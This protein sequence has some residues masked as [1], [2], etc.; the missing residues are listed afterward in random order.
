MSTVNVNQIEGHGGRIILEENSELVINQQLVLPVKGNK[1]QALMDGGFGSFSYDSDGDET[2]LMTP[3]SLDAASTAGIPG[4]SADSPAANPAEIIAA[5]VTVDGGYW[6]D[7][8]GAGPTLTYCALSPSFA[9]G[10]GW[11]LAMK[12][13]RGSTFGYDSSYWTSTN[14]TNETDMSRS[15]AD[16][17]YNVFNY[18]AASSFLAVFPDM[19]N[20]GQT[21]GYGN[22]WSW[23][24]G[25]Q[26]ST[27]LARFQS[28][29]QLSSNPRGENMWSGSGFSNQNG[30]Q[31]YGFNYNGSNNGRVRWGFG[32]NNESTQGSNDVVSGIGGGRN[33]Y[34]A[35]DSIY[36][37]QGT[38][39]INR[40]ARMEI[41]VK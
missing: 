18:Y 35:G 11:M 29:Q 7:I 21:S 40:S 27:A 19:N 38:T 24:Q 9:G 26:N 15:D 5:G 28:S 36:C 25:G 10:G 23:L 31:S 30:Y 3:A 6:I 22:G 37:C 14:T 4:A 12:A 39:G 16:A 33:N 13:T 8:P 1:S 17:K 34:S 41:W 32:W 2:F 20:G